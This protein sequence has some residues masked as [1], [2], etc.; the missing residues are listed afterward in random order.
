MGAFSVDILGRLLQS[1][2]TLGGGMATATKY[3]KVKWVPARIK[4]QYR[5]G[6]TVAEIAR[7]AGYP[8]GHGQNRV[9]SLLMK[10]GIYQTK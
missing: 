5:A 6:K 10:A 7:Q 9:R 2:S 3:R 4:R 8:K 1:G